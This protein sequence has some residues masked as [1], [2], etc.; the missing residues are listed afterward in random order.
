MTCMNYKELEPRTIL[1][2]AT[3]KQ[4]FVLLQK[5]LPTKPYKLVHVHVFRKRVTVK[6]VILRCFKLNHGKVH[7]YFRES[8]KFIYS[9]TDWRIEENT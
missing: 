4:T 1:F 8:V 6:L 5:L 2:Q 9:R 3:P 7:S